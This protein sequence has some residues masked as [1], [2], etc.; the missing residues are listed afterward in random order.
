MPSGIPNE[1]DAG[2]LPDTEQLRAH[3]WQIISCT[4]PY[5]LVW[6]HEQE[7]LMIWKDGGWNQVFV[8]SRSSRPAA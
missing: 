2:L 4:G 3:G 7:V 6:G 5:C 1:R 8:V